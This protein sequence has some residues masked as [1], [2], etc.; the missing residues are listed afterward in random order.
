MTIFTIYR[1]GYQVPRSPLGTM[2][3]H[4][5]PYVGSPSPTGATEQSF[6]SMS[7]TGMTSSF[8][9]VS[10]P[11]YN[12]LAV[13][14]GG[15]GQTD[16]LDSMLDSNGHPVLTSAPSNSSNQPNSPVYPP[17]RSNY[18]GDYQDEPSQQPLC[19]RD[20]LCWAFQIARGMD[21]L[22]RRKVIWKKNYLCSCWG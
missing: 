11:F 10:Y 2:P 7:P 22:A 6:L 1:L 15:T 21:Y 19:T 20:L 5:N 18:R 17:W 8:L 4:L 9:V 12:S 3:P 13:P 16:L 14:G